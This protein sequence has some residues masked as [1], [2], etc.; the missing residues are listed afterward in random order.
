MGEEIKW[1][2]FFNLYMY[3]S[4]QFI[5]KLK[6]YFII[7]YINKEKKWLF[8]NYMQIREEMKKNTKFE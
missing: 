3:L 5:K 7:S 2:R 6:K 4:F 1:L 8:Y